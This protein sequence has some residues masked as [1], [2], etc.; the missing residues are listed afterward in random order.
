MMQGR[1]G[2]DPIAVEIKEV[3]SVTGGVLTVE[4]TQ[5]TPAGTTT[6][7]LVYDKGM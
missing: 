7:K 3:Y 4:R 5:T 2:G 1:G 6:R